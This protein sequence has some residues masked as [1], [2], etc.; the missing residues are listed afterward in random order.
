MIDIERLKKILPPD[1]QKMLNYTNIEEIRI[2]RNSNPLIITGNTMSFVDYC[3]SDAVF[4]GIIDHICNGSYHT[5]ASTI[6]KGYI[7]A[8]NG[9]RVGVC[10]QAILDN[11]R[12]YAITQIN[13]L[14][15]RVPKLLRNVSN[16]LFS[17]FG[18]A[19]TIPSILFFSSPGVGKTTLLRDMIIK[20]IG[21]PY[22]KK[23]CLLDSRE[24]LYINDMGTSP[25]LF[26]YR[27]YTKQSAFEAAVRTMSP[28]VI[29]TDEIA[30]EDESKQILKYQ[31]CGVSI[32]ATTHASSF[33]R[34]IERPFIRPLYD[35]KCFDFYCGINRKKG[36]SSYT[37]NIYKNG[38]LLK[39]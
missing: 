8:G 36:S 39:C 28:D 18:S 30:N 12:V 25:L 37:F 29:V 6:N 33:E 9:I 19:D 27:G 16:R 1:M 20:L 21:K 15:I 2:S 26:V 7:N 13:S 11:E 4:N 38:E 10:G 22:Y 35:S 5:Q 17:I 3:I 34:L 24:E 23:L 14:C 31:N 32:I